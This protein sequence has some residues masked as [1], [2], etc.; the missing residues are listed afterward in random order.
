MS[1]EPYNTPKQADLLSQASKLGRCL[2]RRTATL[3]GKIRPKREGELTGDPSLDVIA[4]LPAIQQSQTTLLD[5]G[6]ETD[7]EFTELAQGLSELN[8][9]FTTIR[10]QAESLDNLLHQRDKDNIL[11]TAYQVYKSSVDLVHASM[12]IAIS[13]QQQMGQVEDALTHAC[14]VKETFTRN[15]LLLRI[16]TMSIRM[17]ASRVDPENQSIFLNVAAAIAAIDEKIA[18]TTE[19]AFARIEEVIEEAR[20]ERNALHGLEQDLQGRAQQSIDKLQQEL[21][22]Y[23]ASLIPCADLSC[24]VGELFAQTCPLTLEIITSLQYQDIVRQQLEHVSAGF[25]DISTHL[26][27]LGQSCRTNTKPEL[28]FIH[29]AASV[30]QTHLA[31][32]RIDIEKA[33]T[34]VSSGITQ[35]LAIGSQLITTFAE[36]EQAAQAAFGRSRISELFKHE[37][38]Q[39][40]L[41]ADQSEKAN[42]KISRLVE[43][44]DEVVRVF[45][46]E[47]SSHEFEVKI[48][49]LNAQIAA[50]RMT[51]ANALNKLAEE[52]SLA[53]DAN[54]AATAELT[55][56]L[57]SCLNQLQGIKNDAD[58]FMNIVTREKDELEANA[59]K[60]ST[61]LANLGVQIGDGS[62]SVRREFATVHKTQNELLGRLRFQTLI[63]NSY[64]PALQVCGKLCAATKAFALPED[65]TVEGMRK[66]TAHQNRYTM[67]R[68]NELQSHALGKNSLPVKAALTSTNAGDIDLFD[69]VTP[70]DT[71]ATDPV[72]AVPTDDMP[73]QSTAPLPEPENS[74]NPPVKK[75]DK[76]D[77]GDGI[78]LF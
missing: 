16:I 72:Q 6:Q 69:T 59:S 9:R 15:N 14:R 61:Q 78:E 48:V 12:G 70:E 57:Q 8:D 38:H 19:E 54:A 67:E 22:D 25:K 71:A 39:L 21:T 50:A 4:L 63:Q 74:A 73:F 18:K 32:S 56:E 30:Q 41:I 5:F 68:E 75:A 51:A 76:E 35:M 26:G 53:S 77:L 37:I 43:R 7:A 34:E 40:A 13:E 10:E 28:G 24:K 27:E 65:L 20:T 31:S 1:A 3:L 47:I 46:Q 60:V 49:S 36:M 2:R 17:E 45:S 33:G 52:S 23:K 58:E 44:I 62:S 55:N 29:H 42:Q 64:D 66:L 11:A